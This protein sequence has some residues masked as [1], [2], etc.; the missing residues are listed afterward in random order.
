MTNEEAITVLSILKNNEGIL[1]NEQNV[2]ALITA[3]SALERQMPKK[4]R[5]EWSE[6]PFSDDAVPVVRCKNCVKHYTVHCTLYIGETRDEYGNS[7]CHYCGATARDDFFCPDG[8]AENE[9]IPK[10]QKTTVDDSEYEDIK[11][12]LKCDECSDR[13][14]CDYP[15]LKEGRQW[16][17]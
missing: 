12:N 16:M 6:S 14:Y 1:E 11:C 15:D 8:E 7:T 2:D 10:H 13:N 3:I 4:P 5:E 9:S 17:N